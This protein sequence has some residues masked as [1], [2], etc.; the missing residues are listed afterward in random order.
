MHPFVGR[1]LCGSTPRTPAL[2]RSETRSRARLKNMGG[3]REP[4]RPGGVAA[5]GR[6]LGN[7]TAIRGS[8]GAGADYVGAMRPERILQS[9]PAGLYCLPG[10]F[11]I[12]PSRPVE[13]AII[14]HAHSDHARPGHAAVAATVE[15]LELMRLRYGENFA[16]STQ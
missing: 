15:T 12:D 14:T 8:R 6:L 11:H 16:G 10:G 4:C 7:R 1:S 3:I 2:S 13:R 5:A 9:T